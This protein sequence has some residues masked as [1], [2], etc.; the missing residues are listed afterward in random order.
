MPLGS[1]GARVCLAQDADDGEGDRVRR[2]G[3]LAWPHLIKD[4]VG[5]RRSLCAAGEGNGRVVCPP[6]TPWLGSLRVCPPSF[7]AGQLRVWWRLMFTPC[8]CGHTKH[9]PVFTV[10]LT[11]SGFAYGFGNTP[12]GLDVERVEADTLTV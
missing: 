7:D 12:H 9:P 4:L 5:R 11:R 10:S 8:D 1:R 2:R 3:V 6:G